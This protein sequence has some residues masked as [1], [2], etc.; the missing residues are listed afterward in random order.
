MLRQKWAWY[1][2]KI[3]KDGSI[4]MKRLQEKKGKKRQLES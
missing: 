3:I 4:K 1:I 2:R